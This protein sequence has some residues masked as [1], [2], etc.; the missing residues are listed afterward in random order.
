M[1]R[2]IHQVTMNLIIHIK[3]TTIVLHIM[4]CFKCLIFT[5]T[6][7]YVT[8]CAQSANSAILIRFQEKQSIAGYDH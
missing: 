7:L 1:R 2:A 8:A 3:Q 4:H 5:M 6:L